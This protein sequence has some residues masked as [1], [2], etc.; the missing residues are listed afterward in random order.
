[1]FLSLVATIMALLL[2]T[3]ALSTAQPGP[4]PTGW[5]LAPQLLRGQELVYRGSFREESL[6]T[7]T[8]FQREYRLENRVLFLD[9]GAA[10]G[11]A[12]VACLTTLTRKDL[13]AERNDASASSVRLE[14]ARVDRQG[15]V[16]ALGGHSLLAP[17]EGPPTTE[18]G[19]FVEVPAHR[20]RR[21]QSW[22]VAEAAR[23]ARTWTLAGTET[24]GGTLC[25]VLVGVQQSADWDQPRADRTAWRRRDTVWLAPRMGW[26]HK[27][28]RTI[29]RRQPARAE[30]SHRSV[31]SYELESSLQFPGQ[32]FDDRRREIQLA[33]S[34]ADVLTPILPQ[35][36]QV[37]AGPFEAILAR[38]E[39]HLQQQPPTPYRQALRQLQLRAEAGRR[40]EAPPLVARE[41]DT[42]LIPVI[43]VGKPAPDFLVRDFT[44]SE[45]ARLRRFL[46]KPVLLLFYD[47][48]ARSAEEVLRFG[49]A[50]CE[51]FEPHVHVVGMAVC[52]DADQVLKQR[53]ELRLRLPILAGSGLK[54]S[55]AVDATPKLIVLDR[56]GIVCGSWVGWGPETAATL[57][58]HLKRCLE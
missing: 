12:E 31:L 44:T 51:A 49:Q 24:V 46:G 7:G 45:T 3:C 11:G 33:R 27:V 28:E 2:L 30:P 40:G 25:V 5:L 58:D 23:P 19:A 18:W 15:R 43:G 29:D 36:G 6:G 8:Q 53:T 52:D 48:A 17:L 42:E 13:P 35:A 16:L 47:P 14:V 55:Y 54:L 39:R 57:R 56:G 21:G 1:L 34:V 37:G 26:A 4:E 20:L 41:A 22:D 9:S 50:L 10:G 32:L 38:L